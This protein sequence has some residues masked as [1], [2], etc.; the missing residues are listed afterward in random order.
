MKSSL[1]NLLI[2]TGLIGSLSF[3]S[4]CNYEKSQTKTIQETQIFPEGSPE[5]T[6]VSSFEES[7]L[8]EDTLLKTAGKY[9]HQGDYELAKKIY[10][11]F[12]EIKTQ[13]K[14]SLGIANGFNNLAIVLKQQGNYE[15]E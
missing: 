8:G 15:K 14:D 5:G 12:L 13:K 3:N 2:G 10:S 4:S 9:F 1:T 11:N 7:S 6:A